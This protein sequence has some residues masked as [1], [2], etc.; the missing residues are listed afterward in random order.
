MS[1]PKAKPQRITPRTLP[2]SEQARNYSP[3]RIAL[4][5]RRKGR[6]NF[7]AL[8]IVLLGIAE[9]FTGSLP[10]G[11]AIG[12]LAI[13]ACNIAH[14]VCNLYID[15]LSVSGTSSIATS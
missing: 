3:N 8:G 14:D 13:L 2:R 4:L 9:A 6:L 10:A 12:G 15:P 7:L 1:S 11:V 5:R